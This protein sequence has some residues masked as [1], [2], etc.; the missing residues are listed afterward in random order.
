MSFIAATRSDWT[1]NS[2]A[3][4]QA[5]LPSST[6]I[7][8]ATAV[9]GSRQHAAALEDHDG[10]RLLVDRPPPQSTVSR[11]RYSQFDPVPDSVRPSPK[12]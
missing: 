8:A 11:A 5:S 9:K 6:S 7:P 12:R 1:T 3:M 10:L 2:T 4:S